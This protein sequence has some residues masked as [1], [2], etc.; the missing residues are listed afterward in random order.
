M[1]LLV[2]LGADV[3][4][5]G[6]KDVMPLN[7]ALALPESPEKTNIVAKLQSRYPLLYCVSIYCQ[8]RHSIL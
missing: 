7:L 6:D 8:S 5:V 3:N 4:A 1:E 2:Q